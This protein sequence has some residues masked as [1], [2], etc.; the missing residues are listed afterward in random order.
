[1]YDHRSCDRWEILNA[2]YFDSLFHIQHVFSYGFFFFFF[3]EYEK[4]KINTHTKI[5]T[6]NWKVTRVSNSP[7]KR[8]LQLYKGASQRRLTLAHPQNI[9]TRL[10]KYIYWKT[11]TLPPCKCLSV[12]K[13]ILN[14]QNWHL[15]AQHCI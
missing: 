11:F 13:R 6:R 1:V 3:F 8:A 4:L 5:I 2:S 12:K 10:C 9:Y 7:K 15:N 14:T